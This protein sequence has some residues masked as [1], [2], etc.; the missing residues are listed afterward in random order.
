M[1]S[2][3]TIEPHSYFPC[4]TYEISIPE[5]YT[6]SEKTASTRFRRT[7]FFVHLAY[8]S[9]T[10]ISNDSTLVRVPSASDFPVDF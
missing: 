10:R 6:T 3:N 8:D 9:R 1:H 2:M 5:A 7:S 4:T